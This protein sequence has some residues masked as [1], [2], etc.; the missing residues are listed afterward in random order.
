MI[1]LLFFLQEHARRLILHRDVDFGIR[2]SQGRD[3]ASVATDFGHDVRFLKLPK[4]HHLHLRQRGERRKTSGAIAA[5]QKRNRF[6]SG[7]VTLTTSVAG[8]CCGEASEELSSVDTSPPSTPPFLG[9][10]AVA[11]AQ[12]SSAS[13][14]LDH[15]GCSETDEGCRAGRVEDC[16]E[17]LSSTPVGGAVSRRRGPATI[18]GREDNKLRGGTPGDTTITI[19]IRGIKHVSSFPEA[20]ASRED[21]R[22]IGV[23][24]DTAQ[25]FVQAFTQNRQQQATEFGAAITSSTSK[26][27][28]RDDVFTRKLSTTPEPWETDTANDGTPGKLLDLSFV[29]NESTHHTKGTPHEDFDDKQ[30]LFSM[31]ANMSG[32]G[33]IAS[34][35]A[36]SPSGLVVHVGKKYS[37]A[38]AVGADNHRSAQRGRDYSED[39]NM[40]GLIPLNTVES[41][42]E[43]ER[44]GR[45]TG[46]DS[47][48]EKLRLHQGGNDGSARGEATSEDPTPAI[49]R[50]IKVDQV[51][52]DLQELL[53]EDALQ[54]DG[55]DCV[56]AGIQT[57]GKV[58][59][60][61]QR[62][63]VR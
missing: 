48:Q 39:V 22:T 54:E 46:E 20:S 30:R 58:L 47:A 63:K 62:E 45:G 57:A 18:D 21:V 49:E 1:L 24:T 7:S 6:F 8:T 35:G 41:T 38:T 29:D 28:R 5:K 15:D 40:V 14:G 13:G 61:Q 9:D 10:M 31:G 19:G 43:S 55:E 36:E 26:L 37:S 12:V 60:V 2:N 3:A 4:G 52:R 27:Y 25:S 33:S 59:R 42:H 53:R 23:Q 11:C 34:S 50:R 56:S 51:T 32:R 17:P 44:D 16:N